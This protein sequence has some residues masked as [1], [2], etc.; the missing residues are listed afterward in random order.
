MEILQAREL[1]EETRFTRER[2]ETEMLWRVRE[3]MQGLLAAIRGP[4]VQMIIEDVCVPPARVGEAAKDLQRLL[5][6]HG[7]LPGVAG[8]ASAGNLHFLLT[9]NFGESADLERYEAF[10]GDLVDLI[11]DRYDGSL[12]AEHGTGI[13]MAPYVATGVGREGHRADVAREGTGRPRRDPRPRRPAH[14]PGGRAPAQPQVDAGDRAVGHAVHRVRLLRARLPKPRPH[15]HPAPA[16]RAAARDGAPDARLAGAGSAARPVRAT[17]PYRPA[18]PTA[19]AAWPARSASTRAASSRTCARA[20]TT[21]EASAS[22][23]PSPGVGRPSSARPARACGW[24]LPAKA[25]RCALSAAWRARLSP[26]SCSRPGRDPM[27][28]PARPRPPATER[29]GR[30]R[31]LLPG[32]RQPH[33]RQR[34]RG[35]RRGRRCRRPSWP[36]RSAPGC[37]SGSPT[38]SPAAAARTPWSS[39]GYRRGHRHMAREVAAAIVR[40]T[41]GGRL[42][43]V[44]DAT[45]CTHG[46]LSDVGEELDGRAARS[47]SPR[48]RSS[49]RSPGSTTRCSPR[50]R[51]GGKAESVAVHP[52][53]AAVHLGPAGEARGDRAR[54]RRGGRRCRSRAPA[55]EPPATAACCT[56]SCRPPRCAQLAERA[57]RARAQRLRVAA[58]ARAR[59]ASRR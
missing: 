32:V 28:G 54:A 22:P 10:M 37:R 11:V 19:R 31:R 39:K 7:F 5:G 40:W 3:G 59:S 21:S 53:A 41:D 13:N 26:T 42:P 36:C 2:A 47:A 46:L 43:L 33:L 15:H 4:G 17:T 27:P 14:A 48:S 44:L 34:G 24:A 25:S 38:T 20:S 29:A 51:C 58:T 8:H 16:H 49:T 1:V 6:E 55:A 35:P 57:R 52:P 9:P 50:C 45:S 56:P 12:K 23:S 30:R 18:P